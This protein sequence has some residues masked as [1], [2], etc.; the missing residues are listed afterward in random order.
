MLIY[1]ISIFNSGPNCKSGDLEQFGKMHASR[2]L[3]L[4]LADHSDCSCIK[5]SRDH[6]I[7][8]LVTP[9]QDSLVLADGLKSCADVR[10]LRVGLTNKVARTTDC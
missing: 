4:L 10:W 7:T 8:H 1:S 3:T 9:L 2:S 5:C 6:V